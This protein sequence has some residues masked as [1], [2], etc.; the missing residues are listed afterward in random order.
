MSLQDDVNGLETELKGLINAYRVSSG[1]EQLMV[2]RSIES[3]Y[4]MYHSYVRNID[5]LQAPNYEFIQGFMLD[6]FYTNNKR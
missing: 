2:G 3:H 5:S 6:E 4:S 1:D